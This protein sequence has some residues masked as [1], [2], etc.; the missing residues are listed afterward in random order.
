MTKREQA[1]QALNKW[2]LETTPD[3]F[4]KQHDGINFTSNDTTPKVE[5]EIVEDTKVNSLNFALFKVKYDAMQ[6]YTCIGIKTG[7]RYFKYYL[8]TDD[9]KSNFES[10]HGEPVKA[11]VEYDLEE[12][13][14]DK[15]F[16]HIGINRRKEPYKNV[17]ELSLYKVIDKND[18]EHLAVSYNGNQAIIFLLT[19][20]ADVDED[21]TY[22]IVNKCSL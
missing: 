21:S 19:R 2:S 5:L 12:V 6:L 22:F 17:Y 7:K 10:L 4:I 14:V 9:I 8:P 16:L 20:G 3:D 15:E 11:I 18:N 1:R 13:T